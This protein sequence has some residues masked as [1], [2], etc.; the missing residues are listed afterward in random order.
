LAVSIEAIDDVEA[1]LHSLLPLGDPILGHQSGQ[2]GDEEDVGVAQAQAEKVDCP[3]E[4][5]GR[6]EEALH[7]VRRGGRQDGERG[8]VAK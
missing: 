1:L 6:L 2:E 5:A 4:E 8:E 3:P 7:E